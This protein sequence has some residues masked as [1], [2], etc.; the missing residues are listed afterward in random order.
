MAEL[1]TKAPKANPALLDK[2]IL[3]VED[4]TFLT[5]IVAQKLLLEKANLVHARSGE[6]GL[7]K[8]KDFFPDII[9]LDLLLPG[10]DGYKVLETIRGQNTY[11]TVPV[12]ILSNFSPQASA[13]EHTMEPNKFLVKVMVTPHSIVQE[14]KSMLEIWK[15]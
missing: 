8:L 10:M 5:A 14:I 6:E 9:L 2:K 13:I 3:W 1:D 15:K 11:D 4:D 7:E 12:I